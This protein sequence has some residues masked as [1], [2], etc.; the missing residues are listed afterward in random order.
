MFSDSPRDLSRRPIYQ[1]GWAY[2][3]KSPKWHYIDAYSRTFCGH[4]FN[5]RL[6]TWCQSGGVP[7]LAERC[8]VCEARRAKAAA[9][10]TGQ[11]RLAHAARQQL[12]FAF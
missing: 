5:P 12:S 4:H 1:G 7:L 3:H 2:A 9:T 8:K 11:A 10:A 6:A